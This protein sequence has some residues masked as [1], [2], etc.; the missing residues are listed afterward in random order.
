MTG[1]TVVSALRMGAVK[2]VKLLL[3]NNH[4]KTKILAAICIIN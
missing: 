4:G 1:G 2:T 3:E